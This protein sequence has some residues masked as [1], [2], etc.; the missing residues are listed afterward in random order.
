[1]R[2]HD[3]LADPAPLIRRVYSYVA[4]R[5]GD[6]PDAEDVTH[7][8]FERA[9]RYRSSYDETRGQPLPWLL[10]IARRC[11]DDARQA[12]RSAA[13][14]VEPAEV[15]SREDLGNDVVQ[16]LTV[17][18]ALEGLDDRA[19][20]LLALRYGADLTARQIGEVLGLKA[21]AVEVALHRTL[22]RLRGELEDEASS[23]TA[24]RRDPAPGT[25][26]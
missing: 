3:P 1:M 13:A 16:R 18:E 19:R 21:N 24:R 5:L 9:L 17:A 20:D 15:A 26:Q 14:G 8:V 22:A 6:G 4:Y 23:P 10:G 12:R 7:D 11:V 2:R 25:S